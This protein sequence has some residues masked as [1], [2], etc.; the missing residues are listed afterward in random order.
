[1]ILDTYHGAALTEFGGSRHYQFNEEIRRGTSCNKTREFF[2]TNSKTFAGAFGHLVSAQFLLFQTNKTPLMSATVVTLKTGVTAGATKAETTDVFQKNLFTG[3]VAFVTGGGS[4]IC[5]GMATALARH[6]AKVAIAGRTA[7]KLEEAAAEIRK[8]TG[9]EVLPVAADVRDYQKIEEAIKATVAKFGRID[10]LVCG[11]A[12]NFLAPAEKLSTNAFRTVIEIDLIGT[13]NTCK[14]ALPYL[15]ETKGSIINV[16]ATLQYAG[17]ALMAHACAAKAGVD[18]LT[19]VLAIEWG[20][21]GIRVNGVAPG[22]I[23]DTTGISKLM[24]DEFKV[25][26]ANAIP[27]KSYG[28]VKDIEHCTV[29]LFSEAGRWVSGSFFV[30]DGGQWMTAGGGMSSITPE[31]LARKKAQHA[32]AKI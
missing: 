22:P 5:K 31:E 12:G 2:E 10:F 27:L 26:G 8:Q 3:K 23:D 4:G 21:Y 9:G 28:T 17:T 6:G 25:I 1:M 18:A 32:K 7:A 29:Y 20:Q 13:F 15:K 24:P 16:T 19:K 11:A 14:A 30:I